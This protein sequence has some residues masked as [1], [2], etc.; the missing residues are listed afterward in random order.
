MINSSSK[1]WED[2][3]DEIGQSGSLV[4][5]FFISFS[6]IEITISE[7]NVQVYYKFVADKKLFVFP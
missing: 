7:Y 6:R 2:S 3:G 5:T 1:N 4:E